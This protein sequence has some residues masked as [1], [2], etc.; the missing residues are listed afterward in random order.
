MGF[1]GYFKKQM[2]LLFENPGSE[3]ARGLPK[4]VRSAGEEESLSRRL[5][6]D[7]LCQVVKIRLLPGSKIITNCRIS[8]TWYEFNT[9][10]YNFYFARFIDF[11][12]GVFGQDYF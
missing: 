6:K 1:E 8:T 3:G 12:I 9:N 4:A 11:W 7:F 2:F 5:T 10:L